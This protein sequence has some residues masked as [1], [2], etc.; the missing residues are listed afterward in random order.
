[1]LYSEFSV[2]CHSFNLQVTT[3]NCHGMKTSTVI[4]NKMCNESQTI[5]LQKHW[6]YP[7]EWPLISK[8]NFT[9]FRLS[10]M[11]L[12]DKLITGRPHGVT[13]IL[14]EKSLSQGTHIIKN[15]DTRILRLEIKCNHTILLSICVYL[16][17][18]YDIFYDDYNF[19]LNKIKT[20]FEST[21]TPYVFVLG[22]FNADIQSDSVF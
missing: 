21:N 4:F 15:E 12:D 11:F 13:G 7:N 18:E 16:P 10:F 14:W 6:L 2:L 5:L 1:M 8:L 17:Y 3:I 9:G 19:Y 20:L 22:D